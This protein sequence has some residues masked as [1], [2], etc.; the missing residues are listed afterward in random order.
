MSFCRFN[1]GY[2]VFIICTIS[3]VVRS[4][5]FRYNLVLRQ[6][7]LNQ[8]NQ[9]LQINF[10][11]IKSITIYEKI[12]DVKSLDVSNEYKLRCTCKMNARIQI[13]HSGKI[14]YDY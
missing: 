4:Y 8:R 6:L 13:V 5:E 11:C 2:N 1:Y 7:I 12:I 3:F 9:K 14:G 10:K